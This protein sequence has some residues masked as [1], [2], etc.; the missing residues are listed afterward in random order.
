MS[1]QRL[2]IYICMSTAPS[3]HAFGQV[4]NV[5]PIKISASSLTKPLN[6]ANLRGAGGKHVFHICCTETAI[7]MTTFD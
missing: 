3:G 1:V 5:K 7:E 6:I 4:S 2:L